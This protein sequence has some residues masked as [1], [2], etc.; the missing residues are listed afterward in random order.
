MTITEAT[1]G[2]SSTRPT[3]SLKGNQTN[4]FRPHFNFEHNSLTT[5]FTTLNVNNKTAGSFGLNDWVTGGIAGVGTTSNSATATPF[6]FA[7]YHGST[8][9]TA[10]AIL[11]Q[12]GKH[13][14][15]ASGTA[16]ASTEVGVRFSNF[17]TM[18]FVHLGS[19]ATS[20][21]NTAP[22]STTSLTVRAQGTGTNN[23]LLV[24]DSAGTARFTVRDDGG[25]AFA[26]GTVGVAQTGYTTFT[27][28]T[29]DRTCDANAT[30]VEELADIL[31]T[32]IVDLKTKGI[33]AA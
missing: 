28:L 20:I 15:S 29:T 22:T 10:A 11:F 24:E 13:N 33:I 30:T 4:Y 7:G 12:F 31:G 19:G 1:T 16:L 25:Y 3:L 18:N 6:F 32:L 27:N 9:P 17:G 23:T 5:P 21:K 26:G 14:G 8:S 2:M